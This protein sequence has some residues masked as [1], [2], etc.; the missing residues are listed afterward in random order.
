MKTHIESNG[1]LT[2]LTRTI[3]DFI[4]LST[5]LLLQ[6]ITLDAELQA[7]VVAVVGSTCG[8]AILGYF[9]RERSTIETALKVLASTISGIFVGAAI[10]EYYGLSTPR[11]QLAV[12]FLS[13]I[14]SITILRALV[15]LTEQNASEFCQEML[16]RVLGL[17][18]KEEREK[19]RSELQIFD[20]EGEQDKC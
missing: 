11:Y 4:F 8:A 5:G 3:F 7:V 20:K 1:M 16:Q 2:S 9:R 19:K 10:E 13:G 14:L 15:R 18:T 17:R 12:Y 6:V